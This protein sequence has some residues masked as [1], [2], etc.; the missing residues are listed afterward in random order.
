MHAYKL[1]DCICHWYDISSIMSYYL[2]TP[3]QLSKITTIYP[4]MVYQGWKNYWMVNIFSYL[5]KL[6][7]MLVLTKMCFTCVLAEFYGSKQYK[8]HQTFNKIPENCTLET[9]CNHKKLLMAFIVSI[10]YSKISVL[11]LFFP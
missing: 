8:I 11:A 3:L 4:F 7:R 2:K 1:S 6:D 5:M 10:F 9:F